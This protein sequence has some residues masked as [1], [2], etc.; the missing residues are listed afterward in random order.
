MTVLV[1]EVRGAVE[2]DDPLGPTAELRDLS[3]LSS[4]SSSRGRREG[5]CEGAVAPL[6]PKPWASRV[7]CA[8]RERGQT[9]PGHAPATVR[10][11]RVVFQ[12]ML[13]AAQ[14]DSIAW[15]SPALRNLLVGFTANHRVALSKPSA[16]TRRL[17]SDMLPG[18]G[19]GQLVT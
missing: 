3:A 14:D 9:Q 12:E 8:A 2:D 5:A 1:P 6:D 13:L 10:C 7:G 17:S 16:Y 19:L 4:L 18:C 15:E 11:R